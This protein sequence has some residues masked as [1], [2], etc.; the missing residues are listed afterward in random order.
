L[1]IPENGI[2]CNKNKIRNMALKLNEFFE[3]THTN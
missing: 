3:F 1:P 2:Q